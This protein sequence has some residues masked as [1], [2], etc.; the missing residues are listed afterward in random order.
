M[1][2]LKYTLVWIAATVITILAPVFL[3]FGYSVVV[4]VQEA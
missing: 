1:F 4:N 2:I 3:L